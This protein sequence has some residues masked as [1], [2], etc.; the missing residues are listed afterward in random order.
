MP[1]ARCVVSRHTDHFCPAGRCRDAPPR[2]RPLLPRPQIRDWQREDLADAPTADSRYSNEMMRVQSACSG[3]S[4]GSI[5]EMALSCMLRN[6]NVRSKDSSLLLASL[7]ATFLQPSAIRGPRDHILFHQQDLRRHDGTRRR[8]VLSRARAGFMPSWAR[9][10]RAN[11]RS[12]RSLRA[13]SGP[14]AGE[15]LL[16]GTPHA[17]RVTPRCTTCGHRHGPP[18]TG[19]LP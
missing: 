3:R 11:P 5:P 8:L 14:T 1:D 19:A 16:D 12:A 10:A 4:H 15:V 6:G 17:L 2:G 13:S 9:T 7:L 18:G